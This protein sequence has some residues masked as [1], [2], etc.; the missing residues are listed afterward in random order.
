ML[1][2]ACTCPSNVSQALKFCSGS[3]SWA[4]SLSSVASFVK[5]L[6]V[7]S[8][9]GS[10]ILKVRLSVKSPPQMPRVCLQAW[11]WVTLLVWGFFGSSLISNDPWPFRDSGVAPLSSKLLK[12]S[13]SKKEFGFTCFTPSIVSS[14]SSSGHWIWG[15]MT[16]EQWEERS[17]QEC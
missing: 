2:K 14:S 10:T 4:N 1:H 13:D 16:L 8:F 15:P 17:G 7:S 12:I 5:W 3:A 9:K 11:D 6:L